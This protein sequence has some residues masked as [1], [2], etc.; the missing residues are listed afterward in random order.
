MRPYILCIGLAALT[1][2]EAALAQDTIETR[3]Q[4]ALAKE[5]AKNAPLQMPT[6]M[7]TEI[8]AAPG[9]VRPVETALIGIRGFSDDLHAT[10]AIN[11]VR[12]TGSAKYPTLGDGWSVVSVSPDGATI[13]KG[14]EIRKLGYVPVAPVSLGGPVSAGIPGSVAGAMPPLPPGLL[15]PTGAV[16]SMP[17]P[18]R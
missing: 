9:R 11:G 6:P 8:K 10:L 4:A 14:K 18:A 16:P 15:M 12:F 2:H 17:M 1:L 13:T 7:G 3:T 5:N